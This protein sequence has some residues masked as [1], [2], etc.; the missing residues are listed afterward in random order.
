M[1]GDET[2]VPVLTARRLLAERRPADAARALDGAAASADAFAVLAAAQLALRRPAEAAASARRAVDLEPGHGEALCH[3]GLALEASGDAAGATDAFRRATVAAS[4]YAPGH[5][6][7]GRMLAAARRLAAAATALQQA[8][9][10][11]PALTAAV[12]FL[13]QVRRD[14]GRPADALAAIEAGLVRRPGEPELLR[15]RAAVLRD[16]GRPGEAL[17]DA[18]RAVDA[19]PGDA[20]ARNVLAVLLIER[21]ALADALPHLERAAALRPGERRTWINLANLHRLLHRPEAALAAARR[22]HALGPDDPVAL[23]TLVSMQQ[24]LAD[25]DGLPDLWRRLAARAGAGAGGGLEPF[26]L[27]SVPGIGR[28]ARLRATEAWL[29]A[30]FGAVAAPP[31]PAAAHD[32]PLRVGYLSADF[33]DHPTAYLIA[34]LIEVHDRRAVSPVAYSFGPADDGAMRRRLRAGFDAFH[35]VGSLS[36]GDA[37]ALIRRHGIDVL[38]DL[39]GY[40]QMARPGIPARRPAP[41]Q[42]AFLGYPGSAGSLFIDWTLC[43]GTVVPPGHEDG[44][45]EALAR[46]PGCYQPNDRHRAIALPPTR[47]EAGLPERGVVLCCFNHTYKIGPE[48]FDRWCGVLA[49]VP[50]AVLWLLETHP[51]ASRNLRAEAE[52]RGIAA[53]RLVFAPY[54]PLP[55]HL[56]RLTLAD[57]ALDTLPYGAH[58]TA[59]DALWAGVPVVPE[60][61]EG[62]AGRV[63]ASLL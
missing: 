25:W 38:V 15:E 13:A 61:W 28:V 22:A 34:E 45:A 46:L 59:S 51:A 54:V 18:R 60:V 9:E 29:A 3:L 53:S 44:Y 58:T 17:A 63:G 41:V 57:L 48:A 36:D 27:L 4:G 24:W 49:A 14:L 16:L 37:A 12:R 20:G 7:L 35:E 62:F 31:P 33:H 21:G 8:V 19:A 10:L 30:R 43:D 39:K 26:G 32:G 50:D 56:A 5:M 11:A 6:H 1:R 23:Q 55:N 42:V 47:A 52:R 40:T 2:N